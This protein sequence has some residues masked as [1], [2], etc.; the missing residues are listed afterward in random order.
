LGHDKERINLRENYFKEYY[1]EHSEEIKER[2][3]KWRESHLEYAR[4]RDREYASKNREHILNRCKQYYL[5]LKLEVLSHYGDKC[6][7]CGVTDIRFLTIDHIHGGGTEHRKRV[8]MGS[9]FYQWLKRNSYPKGYQVLCFSCNL[10]R[11]KNA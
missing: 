8:G 9:S 6:V 10:R 4:K 3:R 1:L 5:K 7:N 2:S 11:K